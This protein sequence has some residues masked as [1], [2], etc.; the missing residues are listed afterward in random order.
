MTK[1]SLT[2]NAWDLNSSHCMCMRITQVWVPNEIPIPHLSTGLQIDKNPCVEMHDLLVMSLLSN[3]FNKIPNYRLCSW[4]VTV[5]QFCQISVWQE[6]GIGRKK[7][8]NLELSSPNCS[9]FRNV[10]NEWVQ[11]MWEVII[12]RLQGSNSDLKRK[13]PHMTLHTQRHQV[14]VRTRQSSPQI[15]PGIARMQCLWNN[16]IS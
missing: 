13:Q 12:L 4:S 1:S 3:S 7:V 14:P 6:N 11:G 15:L 9:Y 8:S 10:L 2:W 5:F 16:L